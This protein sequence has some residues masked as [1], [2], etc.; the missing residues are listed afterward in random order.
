MRKADRHLGAR[1]AALPPLVF[2]LCVACGLW[3]AR[4]VACS[5]QDFFLKLETPE[6][7]LK[8]ETFFFSILMSFAHTAVSVQRGLRNTA[9]GR[10]VYISER[11]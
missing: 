10:E 3:A 7:K 11:F 2:N 9:R 5:L 8:L 6:K 4:S 1:A